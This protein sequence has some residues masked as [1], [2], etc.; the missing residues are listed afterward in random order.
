M[1]NLFNG[2]FVDPESYDNRIPQKVLDTEGQLSFSVNATGFFFFVFFYIVYAF[3]IFIFTT[4]LN[5][6]R[7]LK[8]LFI[9]IFQTRIKFGI[10]NDFLWLFTLNILACG[11]MQFR[12]TDNG[13]DLAMSIIFSLVVLVMIFGLFGFGI[14]KF[15]SDPSQIEDNYSELSEGT[16]DEWQ[17]KFF[18]FAYYFRKIIFAVVIVAAVFEPMVQV[19][20]L[21][22]MF[23]I[24]LIVVVAFRPYQ[25]NLRNFIHFAHEGGLVFINGGIIFFLQMVAAN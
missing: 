24:Y 12:Y 20:I 14:H 7:P 18:T 21:C 16:K 13:G 6:N 3:I 2:V 25:D 23:S 5:S 15:R 17:N 22:A 1:P 4:K 8:N 9:K 10:F 11:F 19:S